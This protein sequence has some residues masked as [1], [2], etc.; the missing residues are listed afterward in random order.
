MTHD[1][2]LP[3]TCRAALAA[4]EADPLAP[5]PEAL[6]HLRA[7]PACAEAR[8]HWLA[9]AEAPQALAPAGYFEQLPGRVARKLAPP[10]A[11]RRWPWIAA[12]LLLM[13]GVGATGFMLGRAQRAPLVEAALPAQE[14]QELVLEAPFLEGEDPV[15]Q[16]SSLSRSEAH[17]VLNRMDRPKPA[18][19]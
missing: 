17:A 1:Y 19:P 15:G 10:Q 8:I 18:Q 6:A 12:A 9:Q 4:I 5:G 13:T 14:A 16:L 7:C 11:P 3:E 2:T